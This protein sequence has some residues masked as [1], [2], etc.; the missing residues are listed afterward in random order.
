MGPSRVF[1]QGPSYDVADGH[2]RAE[3]L[4]W[5]QPAD[6]RVPGRTRRLPIPPIAGKRLSDFAR[7]KKRLAPLT[8]AAGS[9]APRASVE[10]IERQCKPPRPRA[11]LAA[12]GADKFRDRD[13]DPASICKAADPATCP[14]EAWH[15]CCYPPTLAER[16][17]SPQFHDHLTAVA[18]SQ[19]S[20]D[21]PTVT[22]ASNCS[23]CE[24][25]LQ[26]AFRW[27]LRAGRR[28]APRSR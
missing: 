2:G 17:T 8:L 7:Q 16:T 27:R 1:G 3:A 24:R 15:G 21:A 20:S 9:R 12:L 14:T 18:F 11:A 19:P 28:A 22:R 5:S 23:R 13:Y 4:I 10:I 26:H 6:R 25:P